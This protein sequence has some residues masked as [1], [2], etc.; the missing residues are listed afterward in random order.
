MPETVEQFAARIK[1]KYPEYANVPDVE[2]ADRVLKKYPEYKSVIGGNLPG[3]PSP[4]TMETSPAGEAYSLYQH[5]GDAFEKIPQGL[6][7]L[8][9][10]L[11]EAE[12]GSPEGLQSLGHT[13]AETIKAPLRELAGR[14]QPGQSVLTA[15]QS[16]SQRFTGAV[17][18]AT[19]GDPVAGRAALLEHKP[20]EAAIDFWAVPFA[21]LGIGRLLESGGEVRPTPTTKE[22]V[23]AMQLLMG[24]ERIGAS[25]VETAQ[26]TAQ[27]QTVM[28]QAAQELGQSDVTLKKSLPG[29]HIFEPKTDYVG[30]I[31]R[32]NQLALDISKRTV[33]ITQR[34]FDALITTYGREALP[35][36]VRSS[37][38]SDLDSQIASSVDDG[39]RSALRGLKQKVEQA[40]TISDL[41]EI[42]KHANK[43]ADALYSSVPGKGINASAQS[44]YA[45]KLTADAIREHLYPELGRMSHTKL[46]L[47]ELGKREA[48]A[49]SLRDGMHD[50]WSRQV[51]PGEAEREAARFGEYVFGQGHDHSLYSRQILRRAAEKT[52]I[53]GSVGETFNYRTRQALGDI[54]TGM[55]PERVT[56]AQVPQRALPGGTE[57]Y[58]F[59]IATGLPEE[60]VNPA[61]T[62]TRKVYQGTKQVPYEGHDSLAQPS[63]S[64]YVGGT[65][66]EQ[67]IRSTGAQTPNVTI[68]ERSA[69]GPETR[70]QT[71]WQ[72]IAESSGGEVQRGGG[73]VLSTSDPKV[74]QRALDGMRTYIKSSD[75]RN[76]TD[77]DRVRVLE[78]ARKLGKQL[79]DFHAYEGK[80]PP[81]SVTRTPARR[82]M[83]RSPLSKAAR[84]AAAGTVSA[85]RRTLPPIDEGDIPQP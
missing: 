59:T 82:G 81:H 79:Q 61:R 31:T 34:P 38:L 42:K 25:P 72:Q 55:K 70:T 53:L 5:L 66:A 28:Q 19:G 56:T 22:Q 54:G 7:G 3:M 48:D 32:G 37:V 8:A 67:R 11:G 65:P 49:I 15:P 45:Y 2:L 68:P 64:H 39:V 29:S 43:E 36:Q 30:R 33:D 47:A 85:G 52:G 40:H 6:H 60:S 13:A 14:P 78:S 27:L 57:P 10:Q 77:A 35:Q 73:G 44:A 41:Y 26:R 74:A 71:I 1:A 21:T 17:S 58:R 76:L 12:K 62:S 63:G 24:K 75:F 4:P 84:V 20:G 46:D 51:L 69:T 50:L 16:A 18:I 23:S 9:S 80:T 83:S